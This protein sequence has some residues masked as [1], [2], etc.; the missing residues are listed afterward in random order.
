MRLTVLDYKILDE[1]A[2]VHMNWSDAPGG[3]ANDVYIAMT[4]SEIQGMT[5]LAGAQTLLTTKLKRKMQGTGIAAKLDL[6][7][8]RVFTI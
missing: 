6:L 4:D 7:V 2:V 3:E 8:S 1:G 5:D